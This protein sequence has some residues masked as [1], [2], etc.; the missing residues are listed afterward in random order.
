MAPSRAQE[1]TDHG[2]A[3]VVL[4][5]VVLS[6]GMTLGFPSCIGV[7]YKDIQASFQ[8]SDSDT[9]WFPSI[10]TAVLHAG[11]LGLCL[12][13]QA[14][15]TVL[16]YYFIRF[17]TL[18]NSLA[19]T[20]VSLGMALWPLMSQY[21]LDFVDWRGTFLIFG[22]VLLN[23][24]VCGAVMRPIH[25]LPSSPKANVH[26]TPES[27][28]NGNLSP[29]L[30]STS[31]FWTSMSSCS[32]LLQKYMA[33]DLLR[34][35][36]H[37]QIYTFG[38][39][40]MVFGFVLNVYLVPYATA[41]GIEESKAAMLLGIIGFINI[42][43][44]PVAGVIS[45]MAFFKD[46]LYYLFCLAVMVNGASN[47]IAGLWDSYA[48][49]V[50]F[51]VAY[52]ISMSFVGSLVFQVLMDIVGMERFASAFGLFTILESI[53]ILIGPPLAGLLVDFTGHYHYVFY[54]TA[55]IVCSAAL[56]MGI[57]GY[58]LQR[59]EAKVLGAAKLAPREA[60]MSDH[61]KPEQ[62]PQTPPEGK[63]IRSI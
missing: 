18:A 35:N 47:L 25:S 5:A 23:C 19:S 42:F 17:R 30:A 61:V 50:L 4:L 10:V 39:I 49:L 40:C 46:R 43:V 13:F 2:W 9:S 57:S 20:G 6:Q 33:F 16:G 54:V 1:V 59:K 31:C 62:D 36:K 55:V 60:L 29:P 24:C 27:R 48:A 22:G 7:F 34:H 38:N 37:Y 44:R 14:A 58:L 8:A 11:G 51:C 12:S 45:Q 53:T 32:R 21:L 41:S 26:P 56:F 15:I 28:Q 3:W 63:F 52:S